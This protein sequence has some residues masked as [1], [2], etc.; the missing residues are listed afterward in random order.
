MAS[1]TYESALAIVQNLSDEERSILIEKLTVMSTDP[2]SE[3]KH[4]ILELE[5][6]GAEIS[7]GQD[8]D[9]YLR[10]ERNSWND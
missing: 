2:R 7:K 1:S 8:T 10:A 5:G 3:K 6:L 4:S 9:E